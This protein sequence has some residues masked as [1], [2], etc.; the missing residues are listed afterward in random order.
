M[1]GTFQ[2]LV[3]KVLE[4]M[5]GCEAYLDDLIVY[6][7]TWSQHLD[8]LHNVFKQ[9]TGANL[10]LNLSKCKFGQATVTYLGKVVGHGH[11]SAVGA[12]AEA[13]VDFSVPNT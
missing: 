13:I 1:P 11:V 6:R 3:N 10:T 2:R 8:Q 12:K 4:G 9:L 7:A 5:V